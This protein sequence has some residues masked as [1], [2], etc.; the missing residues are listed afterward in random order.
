MSSEYLSHRL[1]KNPNVTLSPSFLVAVFSSLMVY[2]PSPPK[3]LLYALTRKSKSYPCVLLPL[4]GGILNFVFPITLSPLSKI[5]IVK[6]GEYFVKPSITPIYPFDSKVRIE[7]EFSLI[8][9][10][11]VL[12]P[13]FLIS[14]SVK[15]FLFL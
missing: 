6:A 1:H 7:I 11:A 10:V 12:K 15:S 5:V 13:A 14:L 3:S 2:D 8:Y 9:S 4:F